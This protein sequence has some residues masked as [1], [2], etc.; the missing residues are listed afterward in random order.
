MGQGRVAYR[1]RRKVDRA[2]GRGGLAGDGQERY[3]LAR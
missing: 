1:Q 3:E 2:D